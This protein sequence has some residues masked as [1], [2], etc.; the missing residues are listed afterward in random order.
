MAYQEWIKFGLDPVLP[1]HFWSLSKLQATAFY[2]KVME[3]IPERLR[4]LEGLI[5]LQ[6]P[7]LKWQPDFTEDA[8]AVV[9]ELVRESVQT[10]PRTHAEIQE[11]RRLQPDLLRSLGQDVRDW[12]GTDRSYSIAFDAGIYWASDLQSKEPR[13]RW[14]ICKGKSKYLRNQP[15]LVAPAPSPRHKAWRLELGPLDSFAT[16]VLRVA[17]NDPHQRTWMEIYREW[18]RIISEYQRI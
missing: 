9:V 1:A 10:R 5:H 15:V 7:K 11:H 13:F 17:G 14:E 2:T 3:A 6:R 4:Q 8:F 18:N 12:E 16:T